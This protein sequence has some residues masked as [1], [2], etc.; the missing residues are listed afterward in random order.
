MAI[1]T[2][3]AIA[4]GISAAASGVQL[5]SGISRKRKAKR[6]LKNF[7]RQE[8]KNVT[9]NLRVSTLGAELEAQEMARRFSSSVDALRSGGVRGVVGGLG[10]QEQL[11]QVGTQRIG[12][13]LDRDQRQIDVMDAQDEAKIRDMREAR[14]SGA[15][16]GLGMEIA[17]ADRQLQQ[18]AMGLAQTAASAATFIPGTLGGDADKVA[19][20]ASD[21]SKFTNSTAPAALNAVQSVGGLGAGL[22]GTGAGLGGTGAGLGG[23]GAG[24][25][26][27][28]TFAGMDAMANQS[29]SNMASM[30]SAFPSAYFSTQNAAFG[31]FAVNANVPQLGIQYGLNER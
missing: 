7:K 14:E 3:T 1:A 28:S 8:L 5:A 30:Q 15:I 10:R 22:G 19:G 29:L 2:G 18:G 23:A 26:G 21:F 6:A 20:A 16:R 4:L 25:G 11:Q 27:P 12:A 24:L 31:N 13:G 17:S 9:K